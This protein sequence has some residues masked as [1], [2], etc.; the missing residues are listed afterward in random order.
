MLEAIAEVRNTAIVFYFTEL[1]DL[2]LSGYI[3]P[4]SLKNHAWTILFPISSLTA[5]VK[6]G[7]FSH[8][9]NFKK[10]QGSYSSLKL[11]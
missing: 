11:R 7:K 6:S 10:V 2:M 1:G 3:Q 5:T 8:V 9:L 4:S